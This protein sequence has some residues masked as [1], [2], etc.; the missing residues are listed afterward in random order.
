MIIDRSYLFP[1]WQLPIC[2]PKWSDDLIEKGESVAL[3]LETWREMKQTER[4]ERAADRELKKAEIERDGELRKAEIERDR[5]LRKAETEREVKLKELEIRDKEV[6]TGG[7]EVKVT[8]RQPKLPKFVEGQDPD[9]FLKSFE[10]LV[11]LHKFRKPEWAVR[12]VPL[13]SGK[14]L[15]AYSRLH[16]ECNDYEKIKTGISIRYELTA[17]AYRDKFRLSRQS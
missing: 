4:D 8:D 2:Q 15:E 1:E 12:L 16:D 9:V 5:E 11:T 3:C 6:L 7:K 17:E 14:A 13:L 10:R